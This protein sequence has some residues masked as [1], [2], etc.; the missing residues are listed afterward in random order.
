MSCNEVRSR[1]WEE[2]YWVELSMAPIRKSRNLNKLSSIV[3]KDSPIQDVG[4]GDKNRK[5]KRKASE[6]ILGSRWSDEEITRFYRAYRK[7]GKNWKKVAA[8]VRNRSVEMVE[9]LYNENMAYLCLPDGTATAFGLISMM[10]DRYLTMESS[11]GESNE[12]PR[13]SQNAQKRARSKS[14]VNVSRSS[15]EHGPHLLHS[16]A[17]ASSS[18]CLFLL[19]NR[20][21]TVDGPPIVKKRTPRIPVSHSCNKGDLAKQLSP[22]KRDPHSEEDFNADVV[23]QGMLALTGALPEES[24]SQTPNR[25]KEHMRLSPHAERVGNKHMSAEKGDRRAGNLGIG[26]TGKKDSAKDTI[27]TVEVCKKRKQFHKK[28]PELK[29]MRSDDSAVRDTCRMKKKSRKQ[30]S[31]DESSALDAL[32]TLADTLLKLETTSAVESGPKENNTNH[33]MAGEESVC[34]IP[35][36]NQR[37]HQPTSRVKKRK[38]KTI[39]SKIPKAEVDRLC[40]EQQKTEASNKFIDR[41][42]Q[43]NFHALKQKKL[44][45][46]QES[47][48]P[49]AD[50]QRRGNHLP[51]GKVQVPAANEVKLPAKQGSRRKMHFQKVPIQNRL[52]SMENI[53]SGQSNGCS[54]LLHD[55]AHSIKENLSHCL[56]SPT[57][58]KWCAF[59]WFYSAI[60]YPWY[61]KREFVEYLNHVGLGHVPKL[62]RVEWGVIRSSLGKPRRLSQQFLREEK[63]KLEQ[64]RE[65]VRTHYSKLRSGITEVIPWDLTRPLRVGQR[66]IA[67]HPKKG[68][69]CDGNIL[70]FDRDK[71]RV[72]FDRLDLGVELVMDIDCMP[73]DL[74]DHF[75][76]ALRKENF[77]VGKDHGKYK[78]ST[79]TKITGSMKCS[80]DEN[81]EGAKGGIIDA[82]SQDKATACGDDNGLEKA[83]TQSCNLMQ[84]QSRDTDIRALSDLSRALDKKE[85]LVS[86]LRYMNCE[87][88]KYQSNGDESLKDSELFKDQYA[89]VLL[90][91]K[92]ANDQVSSALLYLRQRNTYQLNSPHPWLNPKTRSSSLAEPRSYF[93]HYAVPGEDSG[94]NVVEIVESSRWKAQK[95]VDAAM[96][97][98]SS[99]K[100][101]EDVY[102][103]IE[104]AIDSTTSR[105]FRVDCSLRAR[106]SLNPSDPG[107]HDLPCQNQETAGMAKQTMADET[108][109]LEVNSASEVMKLQMPSALISSCVAT[110]LM[111][112]TCTDRQYP[113]GEAVQILDSA[114]TSLQPICSQNVP[115]Y[116]DIQMCMGMVKNQILALI[117]T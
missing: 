70:T 113:P 87:M 4:C 117:P 91:L 73:V 15:V 64:Y 18:G 111:I 1:F 94:S 23:A 9:A 26:R 44:I 51:L 7:Y 72:Q 13:I 47:D 65:S 82:L 90:Q 108:I 30:L 110:L 6:D 71:C 10:S 35:E 48:S 99:V 88:S 34:L 84:I 77:V 24:V 100:E 16:Q 46:H 20:R 39:S 62:T 2:L 21:S 114:V 41:D 63:D 53:R 19:K 36:A 92:D 74:V 25:R 103:K 59:E 11:E 68:E 83:N 37:I 14:R 75:P 98:M 8:S 115:I 38:S 76:A 61:A 49:N 80:V 54:S 67:R 102:T 96:Q 3:G 112:Q 57:L 12:E 107:H 89:S 95:M 116:R 22:S 85:V 28:K 79:K 86:E 50:L 33:S 104:E 45:E 101:G 43:V 27:N 40:S 78:K 52:K 56:S 66:V 5:R 69:I 29:D 55:K 58:Q 32:H 106:K 60:D 81:L 93:D 97:A 109:D 31:K 17:V 105:D 42:S